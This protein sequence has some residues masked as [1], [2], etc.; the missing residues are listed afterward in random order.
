MPMLN[1]SIHI[2]NKTDSECNLTNS[3]A[4]S[5]EILVS[6]CSNEAGKTEIYYLT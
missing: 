3:E 5:W 2:N 1:I 4:L 6:N